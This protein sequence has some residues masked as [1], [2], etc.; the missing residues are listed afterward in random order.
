[1]SDQALVIQS[2]TGPYEARFDREAIA[3]L[4]AAPPE[5]AHVI[6]DDRVA[7]LYADQLGNVLAGP[8]V[9]RV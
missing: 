5:N 4:N 2:H 1:M 8:S 3:A 7:T 9:L 6:I